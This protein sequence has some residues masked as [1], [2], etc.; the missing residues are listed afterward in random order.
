KRMVVG[1]LNCRI[2][3]VVMTGHDQMISKYLRYSQSVT[4]FKCC[5]HSHSRVRVKWSTNFSPRISLAILEF[6]M[7]SAASISVEGSACKLVARYALPVVSG[8]LSFRPFRI[9]YK[10]DASEAATAR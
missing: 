5:L 7:R 6:F 10:P 1:K 9:P 8:C 4:A 2:D 3:W